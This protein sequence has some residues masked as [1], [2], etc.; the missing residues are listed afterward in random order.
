MEEHHAAGVIGGP[1]LG[2]LLHRAVAAV[3]VADHDAPEAAVR[4]AVENVAHHAEVRLHPQRDGSRK[5]AEVRRDAVGQDGEDRDAEG[6]GRLGGDPLGENAV[7]RQAEVAVLLGAARAATRAVI[8][9]EV[10]FDLH[11]VHVADTH[12]AVPF[13]LV[14]RAGALRDP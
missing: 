8:A 5:L 14:C 3:A 13:R 4:H 7:D 9:L 11:P 10:R 6:F 12:V 2:E 1:L